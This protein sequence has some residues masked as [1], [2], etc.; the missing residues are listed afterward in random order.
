M[1][2]IIYGISTW[3]IEYAIVPVI[4]AM[5]SGLLVHFIFNVKRT[6]WYVGFIIL[7]IITI[8]MISFLITYNK[9][10]DWAELRFKSKNPIPTIV[11]ASVSA[12]GLTAIWIIAFITYFINKFSWNFKHKLN[13]QYVFG[14]LV[15]VFLIIVIMRWFWGPFAYINYHNRFRN[16]TWTYQKYYL[17]FMIP[18]MFKTLIEIPIYALIIFHLKPVI[19]L[20]TGRINFYSQKIYTY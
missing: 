20:I 16:G 17:P 3:M 10:F 11:V 4:I 7:V 6:T 14:I 15:G 8:I 18:I 13:A 12:T 5:I 19:S 1:N 9:P 2:Q